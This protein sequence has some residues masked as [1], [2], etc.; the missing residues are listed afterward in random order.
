M[1]KVIEVAQKEDG[2]KSGGD[3]DAKAEEGEDGADA[4]AS[5]GGPMGRER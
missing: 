1:H 5:Q 4:G 3:K 2:G